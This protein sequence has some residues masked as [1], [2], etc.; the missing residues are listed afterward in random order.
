MLNREIYVNTR[1]IYN[2]RTSSMT[3]HKLGRDHAESRDICQL[4]YDTIHQL[5]STFNV[6][7]LLIVAVYLLMFHSHVFSPLLILLIK[8]LI[9]IKCVCCYKT[10]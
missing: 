2:A 9:V 1:V 4:Y 5:Y 3:I 7:S 8:I 6:G 10:C